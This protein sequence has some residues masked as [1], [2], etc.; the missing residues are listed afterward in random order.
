MNKNNSISNILIWISVFSTALTYIYPDLYAFGMN[1]FFLNQWKYHIY[2]LQ[3]F[4]SN[5][6][7]WWILHLFFNSVFIYYFW[8]QIELILWTRKYLIFFIFNAI[9][10][11]LWLSL[12]SW[13]NTVW[14]S[15]FAL[16]LITY[17]TLD[18]RSKK[19][20]E[21]K[22][23]ITAIIVNVAIWLHP[24]ISLLWHLLW[25]I[26]WAIFYLLNKNFFQ[27]LLTPLKKAN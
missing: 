27:R 4:S 14:I 17:Y 6:I 10:I 2:F 1:N 24:Q 18:L 23:W 5:F 13:W 20:D 8:N 15:W 12:F 21:Y 19:I 26:S 16:A 22:W 9:F 25:A 11:W 3:F 7:H